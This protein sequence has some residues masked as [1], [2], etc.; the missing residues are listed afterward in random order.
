MNADKAANKGGLVKAMYVLAGI[1]AIIFIFMFIS[2]ISYISSYMKAYGM[3]FSQMGIEPI[4]YVIEGSAGY[5]VYAVLLFCAA[6][7][8]SIVSVSREMPD[9]KANEPDD[10]KCE[11]AESVYNKPIANKRAGIGKIS[12]FSFSSRWFQLPWNILPSGS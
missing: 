7:V 5:L 9:C 11:G 6:K 1:F 2:E 8:I 3:P 12:F 10:E 4:K